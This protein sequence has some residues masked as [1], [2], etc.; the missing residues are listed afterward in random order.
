M[1]SSQYIRHFN[2]SVTCLGLF[3]YIQLLD[4]SIMVLFSLTTT[5][6]L[7]KN[8]LSSIYQFTSAGCLKWQKKC[9]MCSTHT[10]TTDNCA[11]ACN[12]HMHFI[13][14]L[15]YLKN[16]TTSLRN[17]RKYMWKWLSVLGCVHKGRLSLLTN[18][19]I[20]GWMNVGVTEIW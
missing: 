1:D 3:G 2:N 4:S 15:L 13:T 5:L 14:E 12:R 17:H 10:N 18:T 16:T 11:N 8:I 7:Q 9:S 19:T 20:S 6:V